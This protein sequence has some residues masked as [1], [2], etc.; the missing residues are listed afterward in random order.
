MV[1]TTVIRAAP[2]QQSS[3]RSPRGS[4]S[5]SSSTSSE[6]PR[7]S[8]TTLSSISP[9]ERCFLEARGAVEG[10]LQ[11]QFFNFTSKKC[12]LLP[13][14][15]AEEWRVDPLQPSTSTRSDIQ[16]TPYSQVNK[17]E[18]GLYIQ[19]SSGCLPDITLI[20]YRIHRIRGTVV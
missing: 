12:L 19:G 18:P 1:L 2:A 8:V 13:V 15:G 7:S 14:E 4:F 16:Q 17:G 3:Y 10:L 11:L 5:S 9:P 6:D 20:L